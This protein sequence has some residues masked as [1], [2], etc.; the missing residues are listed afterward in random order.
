M[1]HTSHELF[2]MILF[3]L[4][5]RS[6]ILKNNVDRDTICIA[7]SQ[8]RVFV[9][10]IHFWVI[11]KLEESC[12]VFTQTNQVRQPE[13][14][15]HRHCCK[16]VG[17]AFLKADDSPFNLQLQTEPEVNLWR[18]IKHTRKRRARK[19]RAPL[20]KRLAWICLR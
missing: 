10:Q 11:D 6:L 17:F 2:I 8:P 13:N 18:H 12:D 5:V 4:E 14:R 7:N 20:A 19:S 1:T 9:L 16:G 3:K 15:K